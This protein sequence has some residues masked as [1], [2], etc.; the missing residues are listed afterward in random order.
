MVINGEGHTDAQALM[1]KVIYG[2]GQHARARDVSVIVIFCALQE[3]YK[4]LY[5]EG[6]SAAFST[7]RQVASLDWTLDH[8][9]Q[10]LA[11]SAE[12]VFRLIK[13]IK[14]S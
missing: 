8:A 14:M 3:G 11:D 2:V 13:T 7:C 10:N 6:V 9:R 5:Q 4:K 12:D 1:S